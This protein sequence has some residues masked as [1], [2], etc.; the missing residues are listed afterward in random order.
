MYVKIYASSIVIHESLEG[1][2]KWSNIL[3][4][5]PTNGLATGALILGPVS[6]LDKDSVELESSYM[7][8]PGR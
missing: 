6:A 2:N 4:G 8:T 5:R 3:F 7:F 1:L